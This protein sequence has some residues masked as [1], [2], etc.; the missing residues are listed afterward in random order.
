MPMRNAVAI[1]AGDVL[2]GVADQRQFAR[3]EDRVAV[4]H[5]GN[6][7]MMQIGGKDQRDAKQREKIA[8]QQALLVLGRVDGGDEAQAQLLGDD[9]AGD[10]QRRNRQPRGQAEDRADKQFLKQQRPAPAR[11]W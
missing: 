9:G 2:R 8:D 10:L 1:D 3:L 11:R 7:E 5:R 4:V 6:D